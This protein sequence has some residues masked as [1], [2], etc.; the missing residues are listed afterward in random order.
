M[1]ADQVV[2]S[3]VEPLRNVGEVPVKLLVVAGLQG[4]R[5]MLHGQAVGPFQF[6]P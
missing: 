5:G 2:E 6:P 3:L 1:L 4:F